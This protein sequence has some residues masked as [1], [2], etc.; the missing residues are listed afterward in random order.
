M[1]SGDRGTTESKAGEGLF[2]GYS[3]VDT[4]LAG[5]AILLG[6]WTGVYGGLLLAADRRG[7]LPERID[8][9]DVLL[10]GV[11]THKLTRIATKDWV[12]APIRAPF[13]RYE[14]S[15]GGGEVK[16]GARGSG[17]R[18]AIG[19]LLTCPWCTGPW[20]GGALMAALVMRPRATRVLAAGFAAVAVS[21]FIHSLYEAAKQAVD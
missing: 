21:D 6:A 16:E 17:L 20:V 18:K 13:V 15:A 10:M 11:A 4:P 1:E 14:G 9:A 8:P 3:E 19:D 5:Y 2:D 7:V 12:T